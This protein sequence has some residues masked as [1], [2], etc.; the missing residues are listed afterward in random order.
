[1]C[2]CCGRLILFFKRVKILSLFCLCSVLVGF[3][4]SYAYA[5]S[6]CPFDKLKSNSF[7][8]S[9]DKNPLPSWTINQIHKIVWENPE[10]KVLKVAKN[11]GSNLVF[12]HFKVSGDSVP[13]NGEAI[14]RAYLVQ[15][16]QTV[17]PKAKFQ[18]IQ[19]FNPRD[20]ARSL[21]SNPKAIPL[22]VFDYGENPSFFLEGATKTPFDIMALKA[23]NASGIDLDRKVI[24]N[25]LGADQNSKV[26]N[27]YFADGHV[28]YSDPTVQA[29]MKIKSPLNSKG[30][31]DQSEARILRREFKEI[32]TMIDVILDLG[33]PNSGVSHVI[34][35][36]KTRS[37]VEY[38]LKNEDIK[39][40]YQIFKL[41]SLMGGGEEL[42]LKAGK[43]ILIDNDLKGRMPAL[44]SAS[45]T[46]IVMGPL[47]L[48]E[49]L[50]VG[51]PTLSI[52]WENLGPSYD[53]VMEWAQKSGAFKAVNTSDPSQDYLEAFRELMSMP[54][55]EIPRRPFMKNLNVTMNSVFQKLHQLD[56]KNFPISKPKF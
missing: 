49:P 54:R 18:E 16:M 56:P 43:K 13:K 33:E 4:G 36:P 32:Q 31:P 7:L 50:N 15:L 51:T 26:V 44:Y 29:K 28:D 17:F 14:Q 25:E 10:F 20:M 6:R 38:I 19:G 23:S 9:S 5:S 27:F 45:D 22:D 47:N 30:S 24:R 42:K 35:S 11:Q 1:M 48:F 3:I 2:G 55:V 46:A 12:H 40:R 8:Q 39:S 34:V 41:S 21:Q 37:N 52:D 53:N